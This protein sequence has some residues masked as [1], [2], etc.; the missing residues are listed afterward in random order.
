[1]KN[2]VV[3]KVDGMMCMHCAARVESAVNGVG[4]KGT[5]NLKK[6]SVTVELGEVSVDVVVKAIEDAG[7]KVI[8]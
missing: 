6:K 5:V 1:M 2:E 4:A 8:G 7:Y 3:L